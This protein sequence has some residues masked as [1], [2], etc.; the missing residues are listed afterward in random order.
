MRKKAPPSSLPD[1][2][3]SGTVGYNLVFKE[4]SACHLG[5][6]LQQVGYQEV[7]YWLMG[8]QYLKHIR[9]ETFLLY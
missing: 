5:H 6:M 1:S 8:K 2:I 4:V 7:T 9:F 3:P